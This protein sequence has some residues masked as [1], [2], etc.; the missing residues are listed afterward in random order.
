MQVHPDD[1]LAKRR[2]NSFGKTEMWYILDNEPGA[3]LVSGLD[4]ALTATEY[5]AK[6][7]N[8]SIE[9]FL[10]SYQVEKGQAF[11]IPAG[12]VHAIGAGIVLAEVQQTSD[13]TYRIYDYNRKDKNG[14]PR[15][16]HTEESVEAVNFAAQGG[17]VRQVPLRDGVEH[18][19]SCEYFTVRSVDLSKAKVY[20]PDDDETIKSFIIFMCLE[21]GAEISYD[22]GKETMIKGETVLIPAAIKNTVTVTG[23]GKLLQAYV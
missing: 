22:G 6:I 21:G 1:A 9:N 20:G 3:K 4:R 14:Q 18:V 19:V 2:H 5:V 15:Q 23:N 7:K 13:I 12:L 16:L 17:P 8:N 11:F 10:S